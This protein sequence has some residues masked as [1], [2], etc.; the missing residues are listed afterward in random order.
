MLEQLIPRQTLMSIDETVDQ[1]ASVFHKEVKFKEA[2]PE[3]VMIQFAKTRPVTVEIEEGKMWITLRVVQLS[4]GHRLN[5]TN[6]IVRAVYQ[7]EV[8]GLQARLVRQGHL[9]ISGPGM[10][11]RERLP[12]RTIFNKVLSPD[13][14]FPVTLPN[15]VS[16]PLATGLAVSQLE[17]RAGW[18]GLAVS[19]TD[20]PRIAWNVTP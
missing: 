19:E 9:R 20:A 7:P 3:G 13:R 4:R 10:S 14:P 17:L 8:N 6:F 15:L 11:M 1:A 5:L 16:N 12:L 2:L 18:I